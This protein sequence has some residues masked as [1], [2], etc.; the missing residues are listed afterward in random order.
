M[1][2]C[3]HL[4]VVFQAFVEYVYFV[5]IRQISIS[6]CLNE[7]LNLRNEMLKFIMILIWVK[8]NEIV[9]KQIYGSYKKYKRVK[10]NSEILDF[11]VSLI[12]KSQKEYLASNYQ[13]SHTN[14]NG[15]D[16]LDDEG[17]KNCFK[18]EN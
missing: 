6:E 3:G 13:K 5:Y 12:L 10:Y 17:N 18:G 15:K 7:G 14:Q 8:K 4:R 1:F 9:G 16:N 11:T 2:N